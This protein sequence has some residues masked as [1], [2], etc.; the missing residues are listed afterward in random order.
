LFRH[1][2]LH[3]GQRVLIHAGSGGVGHLAVQFA[4]AMG[5]YVITTV[6]EKHVDFVCRLGADEVID[7]KRQRF[8]D[9]VHDIDMVFDLIGGETQERS[10]RVLREGGILVSTL[11]AP[12]QGKAR[13]HRVRATRYTA[14][15]SGAELA[16]IA[17]LID[18]GKVTPKVA[19]QF[20]LREVAEAESLVEQ[21]HTEGKVVLRI[22]A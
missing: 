13:A 7:Y 14:E 9:I 19:R 15:E 2:K 16:E 5:A 18:A 12:S 3:A 10:F 11:T 21:G 6:S 4:K 17:R 20:S 22:A 8:D 1:G